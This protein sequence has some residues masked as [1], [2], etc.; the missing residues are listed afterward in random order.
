MPRGPKRFLRAARAAHFNSK[1][2]RLNHLLSWRAEGAAA[3]D[4]WLLNVF[5]CEV[6]EL[7]PPIATALGWLFSSFYGFCPAANIL[8]RKAKEAAA[9]YSN[10]RLLRSWQFEPAGCYLVQY[11]IKRSYFSNNSVCVEK[12]IL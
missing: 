11:E 4:R 3:G 1:A 7:L 6:A 8:P 5:A 2:K 10:G 12:R 9:I